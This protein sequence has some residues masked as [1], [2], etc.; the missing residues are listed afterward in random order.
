MQSGIP[1]GGKSKPFGSRRPT[2]RSTAING[3][4]LAAAAE[5]AKQGATVVVSVCA[6]IAAV[7]AVT[8]PV[9][10][11]SMTVER[12][13]KDLAELKVLQKKMDKDLEEV[14]V[15]Q[16]KIAKKMHIDIDIEKL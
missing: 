10:K 14:K 16:K 7:A 5:T 13:E 9:L 6:G 12:T 8:I 2:R 1:F 3:F 4:N 15:L 11:T